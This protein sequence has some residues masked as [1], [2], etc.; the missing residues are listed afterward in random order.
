M[1][2]VL[3]S[4]GAEKMRSQLYGWIS[5]A[6]QKQPMLLGYS[7]IVSEEVKD[8]NLDAGSNYLEGAT[9]PAGE[10]WVI[11]LGA[12]MYSGTS[13]TRIMLFT[14]VSGLDVPSINHA[15]P[16]SG[17]WYMSTFYTVLAEGDRMRARVID[18]TAGDLFQ[19]RYCGFKVVIDQ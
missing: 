12:M 18:A 9:V 6:W 16:A 14:R 8:T 5:G 15:S 11:T 19:M 3:D 1:S 2:K 10:I 4:E 13:P 17:D 7:G